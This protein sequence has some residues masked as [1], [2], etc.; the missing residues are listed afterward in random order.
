M[1]V[2]TF[3][4]TVTGITF[5]A[6]FFKKI[7]GWDDAQIEGGSNFSLLDPDRNTKGTNSWSLMKMLG[8]SNGSCCPKKS[9][10]IASTPS[11]SNTNSLG[12]GYG[13]T[14]QTSKTSGGCHD[15]AIQE[16]DGGGHSCH[17]KS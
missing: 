6:G 12:F 2:I 17:G 14:N 4:G 3:I 11:A 15:T 8:F 7:F 10:T 9:S 1:A 16:N 13:S 5:L